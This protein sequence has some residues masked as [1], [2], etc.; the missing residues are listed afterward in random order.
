MVSCKAKL[1][2]ENPVYSVK[3]QGLKL[4]AC[5]CKCVWFNF[6]APVIALAYMIIRMFMFERAFGCETLYKD[7]QKI[8]RISSSPCCLNPDW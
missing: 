3:T 6:F 5:E 7:Y 8:H 2:M 1:Q 4:L